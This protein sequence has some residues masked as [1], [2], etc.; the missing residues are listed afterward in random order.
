MSVRKRFSFGDIGKFVS[1]GRKR[2]VSDNDSGGIL[3]STDDDILTL[4]DGRQ[5]VTLTLLAGKRNE[6]AATYLEYL[7]KNMG[8]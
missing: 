2:F 7:S 5:Q 3:G 1:G 4:D 8:M 6:C